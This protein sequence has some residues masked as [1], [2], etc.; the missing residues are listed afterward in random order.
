MQFRLASCMPATVV[1]CMLF[2]LACQSSPIYELSPEY[3]PFPADQ[4]SIAFGQ[5]SSNFI[6]YYDVRIKVIYIN[7]CDNLTIYINISQQY[8]DIS[9]SIYIFYIPVN[10]MLTYSCKVTFNGITKELQGGEEFTNEPFGTYLITCTNCDL[11][12]GTKCSK[13]F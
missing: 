2:A 12:H 9:I 5:P 1:M 10:G 11:A 4:T 8:I 13:I 7:C 3:I 6:F